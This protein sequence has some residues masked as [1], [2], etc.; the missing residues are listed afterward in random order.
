MIKSIHQINQEFFAEYKFDDSMAQ[1]IAM[2]DE[3]AVEKTDKQ[4]WTTQETVGD[5]KTA[6]AETW[7]DNIETEAWENDKQTE[8]WEDDKQ[9][10]AWEDDTEDESEAW[11]DETAQ[12]TSEPWENESGQETAEAWENETG[13]ETAEAWENETAK[14]RVKEKA[15][16][17]NTKTVPS[18]VPKKLPLWKELVYLLTKVLLITLTFALLSTFLFGFIRYQDPSMD[19]AIKDGDLVIF[20]RYIRS[21][22]LPQDAVALEYKGQKQVR[23]VVATA[24]DEVDISEDGLM[25]NGAIQQEPGIYQKT[26]R[27]QDGVDFPLIVPE[28]HVFVLG[29]F[30]V[31]ATDSR[32]YGCVEIDKTLGKVMTI[33][34]RRSI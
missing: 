24:G 20:Y 9:A 5:W 23:R 1:P 32:V 6:K 11:E 13:V 29:D 18:Q 28:G 12:E 19:P 3:P 30:R 16:S 17:R 15:K 10:E 34:R 7:E 22:Y 27:Y 4:N 2:P 25:V 33:L 26:E 21:G 8:A 31:D 14:V